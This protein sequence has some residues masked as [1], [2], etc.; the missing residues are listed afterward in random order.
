M[1]Q[2]QK[3]PRYQVVLELKDGTTMRHGPTA[4]LQFC[5]RVCEGI[6]RSLIAGKRSPLNVTAASIAPVAAN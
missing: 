2:I 4:P 5:Q 3:Q 6:N 1:R